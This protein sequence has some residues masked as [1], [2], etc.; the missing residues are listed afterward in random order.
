MTIPF[1]V[2]A[3]VAIGERYFS[4]DILNE[5][6]RLVP[7]ANDDI[8]RLATR[9]YG[10]GELSKLQGFRAAFVAEVA[11]RNQRRSGGGRQSTGVSAD[12]PVSAAGR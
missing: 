12:T 9:G 8:D 1:T 2:D 5:A 10:Q 4:E 6:D 7:L 11:G 3:F